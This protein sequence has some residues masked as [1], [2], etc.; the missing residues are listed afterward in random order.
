LRNETVTRQY[1]QVTCSECGGSNGT[2]VKASNESGKKQRYVHASPLLCAQHRQAVK[3]QQAK[4]LEE[5]RR[6]KEAADTQAAT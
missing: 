6:L 2:L 5:R 3:N 4:M 1:E